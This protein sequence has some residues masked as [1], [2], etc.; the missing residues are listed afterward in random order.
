M[1]ISARTDTTF[2]RSSR[3]S[4]GR[5][6]LF[7]TLWLPTE[8]S[9]LRHLMSRSRSS[10]PPTCW[11]CATFT[12]TPFPSSS[13]S[14]E[15]SLARRR[16]RLAQPICASCAV[17]AKIQRS[18]P[19]RAALAASYCRGTA[20]RPT[21]RWTTK[22]SA[23]PTPLS[24]C[25]TSVNLSTRRQSS[26]RRRQTWSPSE[27]CPGICSFLRTERSAPELCPVLASL[28][29]A[30]TQPSI[31]ASLE[32]Q[33]AV[34]AQSRCERLTCASSASKSTRKAPEDGEALACF[35]PPRK[36]SSRA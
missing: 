9:G 32:R 25:T 4:R 14:P 10:C 31:R 2:D 24:S 23:A 8:G 15:L 30:S 19:S 36:T 22:S 11:G 33:A 7:Y 18:S 1:S 27:S 13:G 17:T 28:P 16:C 29:R 21:R 6:A 5:H 20:T 3:P 12:P 26:S 34:V 35:R